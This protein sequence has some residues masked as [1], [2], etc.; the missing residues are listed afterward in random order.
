MPTLT[1]L[2]YTDEPIELDRTR[3]YQQDPPMSYGKPVGLWVSVEG[4][5]DWRWWCTHEMW[6][7]ER[8]TAVHKVTLDGNI[9]VLDQIADLPRFQAAYGVHPYRPYELVAID[10]QRVAADYDGIIIAPYRWEHRLSMPWYYGWDC[11]SG[12][13]W[14]L[15]A[16][17][18]FTVE[19][20]LTEP[21]SEGA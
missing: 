11:A 12:C 2:H 9:L 20:E 17:S 21:A 14:N 8:L 6:G 1:L 10:W 5:D 13:V 4:K 18:S 16:V 15:N 19:H 7:T 3:T